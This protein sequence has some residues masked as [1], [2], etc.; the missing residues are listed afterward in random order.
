[1][2]RYACVVVALMFIVLSVSYGQINITSSEIPQ[3]I[4]TYC[5]YQECYEV[6]VD[7]GNPGGGNAWNF[8]SQT[9]TDTTGWLIVNKNDTPF[10]N[11]FP[12]ANLVSKSVMDTT[13]T[14][15]GYS[16]LTTSS[17]SGLGAGIH[18][19]I[20]DMLIIYDNPSITPLPINYG[21][22]WSWHN[23][24]YDTIQGM[25]MVTVTDMSVQYQVDAWGTVQVPL[26]T[27]SCLR[28]LSYDTMST[29][30]YFQGA[31]LYGDTLCYISYCFWAETC[32]QIAHISSQEGETNPNFT[33]AEYLRRMSYFTT[34]VAEDELITE[35]YIL[36]N[37]PNPFTKSTEICFTVPEDKYVKLEVFNLLGEKVA[38]L[39]D[40]WQTSGEKTV[41]WDSEGLPGGIYL[42]RIETENEVRTNKMILLR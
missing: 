33:D 9:T 31:P 28:V 30:T 6:T 37:Y 7:V 1:M 35:D 8:T 27:Y 20:E 16:E 22:N 25:D 41:K 21:N 40:D 17:L 32:G 29:V 38:T 18:T 39:V 14:I 3:Q 34:G 23:T 13:V 15:Y 42:Y 5:I 19:P 11:D 2:K 36:Q 4:G 26:G 10:A 12:T 24:D